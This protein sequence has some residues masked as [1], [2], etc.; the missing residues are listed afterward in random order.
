MN[1]TPKDQDGVETRCENENTSRTPGEAKKP[2][3]PEADII[4]EDAG[5]WYTDEYDFRKKIRRPG[6]FI[7]V[8]GRSA[9]GFSGK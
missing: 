1:C 4:E 2:S 8:T 7:S 3:L 6:V 5:K 9:E